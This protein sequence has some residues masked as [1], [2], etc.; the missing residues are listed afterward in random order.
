MLKIL[1]FFKKFDKNS[2]FSPVEMKKGK[3]VILLPFGTNRISCLIRQISASSYQRFFFDKNGPKFT[4][5]KCDFIC[6]TLY[7]INKF[8]EENNILKILGKIFFDKIDNFWRLKI[9]EITKKRN[10]EKIEEKAIFK[11]F[12]LF[13]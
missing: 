6:N 13:F 1:D 11:P 4:P 5:E 8:L 12:L 7:E 2:I 3:V 10:S 9:S